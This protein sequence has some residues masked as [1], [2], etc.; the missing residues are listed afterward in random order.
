MPAQTIK[1]Y[2]DII[3]RL[4]A[5]PAVVDQTI[6]LL[7]SGVKLGITPPRI[8]LAKSSSAGERSDP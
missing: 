4:R 7:D 8:T 1:D 2:T 6:A 5:L 3:A